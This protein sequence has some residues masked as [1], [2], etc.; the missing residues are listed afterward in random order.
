MISAR[1]VVSACLAAGVLGVGTFSSRTQNGTPM[2]VAGEEWPHF[3]GD[4]SFTR[5]SPLAQI[6]RDNVK[7]LK[8]LWRRP[9]VDAQ[10]RKAFPDVTASA[11]F[12]STPAMV[13]GMLY[14]PNGVGLLEAFDASTGETRWV[15]EPF[16]PTMKE[17]A[18]EST[19]GASY[20]RGKADEDARVVFSRGEYLYAVN[21]KTGKLFRDFGDL[22][23]V[24]LDRATSD[25]APYFSWNPPIVVNDV[26]VVG[27]NG[28]GKVGGGYGDGGFVK[29][30]APED[31]RGYDVR[32][33]KPLW[34]FHVVP[35]PGEPGHDSWGNDSWKAAGNLAVWSSIA[36]DEEL[37]YVYLP[38]TAPTAS[39]YGGW[40]PG[41]NLY[42]DSLV[43]LNAKTGALVWHFQMVHH[44]LWEY[45]NVGPPTLGDITVDGRRIKAIIQAS[46]TAFLYVF[47]RVTGKP[48]WP[49]EER[50]VPQST[51]PGERSSPTQP[52]PTKPPPF[53]RQGITDDDLIDFTPA[54]RAEAREIVRPFVMGPIF[55]PGSVRSDDP[56]GKK[57]TIVLPGWYGGANWNNG[58]FDPETGRYYALS[59]TSPVVYD[60]VKPMPKAQDPKPTMEYG[61]DVGQRGGGR[62]FDLKGPQG[63]P[64]TK[65]PYGRIT[66]YDMNKGEKLWTIANGDGPRDHPLL[67]PLNLPP[68]G[69][70]GRPV[71]LLTKTLLFIGEGS[72]VVFG[73]AGGK[74]FRAYDKATGQ[75]VSEIE[76]PAGTTGAPM[77]YM[78]K[79][80][81]YIVVP[82]G[83]KDHEP[84]WIA[85]G[86]P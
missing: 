7:N 31:I 48:V 43:A 71:P 72:E 52:F 67:K 36:A 10:L 29:E 78:S 86:L 50:P 62:H 34:T 13:G 77:T 85:L 74:K 11:Y 73:S 26:I 51:V 32:T 79:G 18:G 22:G 30:A 23:R 6:T 58:A 37:G 76:L 35:R 75:M 56:D 9:A 1:Q 17:A 60:L 69:A 49:I 28:G 45:D 57:G 80:K 12:R 68:L 53:D 24:S 21:A 83:S 84:E 82:V 19:R 2:P 4:K 66:A 46:K 27:G 5:Y 61:I 20:W 38:L 16:H 55:T 8:I 41:D 81:Q 64:L 33:G 65:P 54:L 40:R 47:D 3:G 15:Q 59:V 44:D 25:Q 70:P 42:S 39:Y 63:L 14:A